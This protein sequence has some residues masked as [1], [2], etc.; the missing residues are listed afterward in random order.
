MSG[1]S[2]LRNYLANPYLPKRLSYI[3]TTQCGRE[4]RANLRPAYHQNLFVDNVVLSFLAIH[5]CSLLG[6]NRQFK[7][8]RHAILRGRRAWLAQINV[9]SI[10]EGKIGVWMKVKVAARAGKVGRQLK[11]SEYCSCHNQSVIIIGRRG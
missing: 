9:G 5:V 2:V 7:N 1:V 11:A 10:P 6:F 8:S 4:L 3:I